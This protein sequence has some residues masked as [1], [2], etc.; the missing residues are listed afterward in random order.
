MPDDV[1]AGAGAVDAAL[2]T[3]LEDLRPH[4]AFPS[5][6]GDM[7]ARATALRAAQRVSAE[8]ASHGP[9][10]SPGIVERA[11]GLLPGRWATGRRSARRAFVVAVVVVVLLAAAAAAATLGVR[12]IR[13]IFGPAPSA[14][15]S[16]S[17]PATG[18]PPVTAVAPSTPTVSTPAPPSPD[19]ALG[20][21][22]PLEEI[23]R[24]VGFSVAVPTLPGLG[25]PTAYLSGLVPGGAVNLVYGSPGGPDR[26]LIT[27]FVG[28]IDQNFLH[29]Y[30]DAGTQVQEARVDGTT[31]LWVSGEPHTIAYVDRDGRVIFSSLRPSGHALLWQREEVTLRLET[32]LSMAR[33]I[34]IAE[35][36]R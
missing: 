6:P 12:G 28:R 30:I 9:A 32:G 15:P 16:A 13:L 21:Q 8:P 20:R 36:M 19:G 27:E 17:V 1:G 7:F 3:A 23:R 29:K 24:E 26:A 11:A 22:M 4:L 31:G 10:R 34:A 14:V 5:D 25:H 18:R 2:A 33:A 35:S